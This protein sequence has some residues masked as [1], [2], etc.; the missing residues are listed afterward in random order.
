VR[1]RLLSDVPLGV[2]LSGGLDSSSLVACLREVLGADQEIN[3]FSIGF[4]E[5]S[6]DE[7]DAARLVAR[8]FGTTHHE[9]TFDDGDMLTVLPEVSAYL[10]EPFADPSVLPTYLLCRFA[11]QKVKVALGG[12]GGDELLGGYPTFLATR[13]LRLFQRLPRWS[14]AALGRLVGRLPVSHRNMSVDFLLREYL[15]GAGSEAAMANQIW[16]GAFAPAEQEDLLHADV[17]SELNGFDLAGEMLQR[18]THAAG[19]EPMAR[20]L[21]LYAQTYLQEEILAKVD[22][23][24]MA[25]GLEVRAPFLDPELMTF[26]GRL[27]TSYRLRGTQTKRILKKAA[28]KR[29][30]AAIVHR[31][32][33][34]FGIPA[35]AWLAGSLQEMV[36]DLLSADRVKAQGLFDPA[37]VTRL[38]DE[39]LTHRRNHRKPLWTL[40]MFQLW[41][42]HYGRGPTGAPEAPASHEIN[43]SAP[44]SATQPVDK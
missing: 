35:A 37:F 26:L 42:D 4:R 39:H 30:P 34:G 23:A 6:Y 25:N 16:M 41:Y 18:Y 29:L 32:K 1:R 22:R 7:S 19:A 24:S 36:G 11:R 14:R 13:S 20:L 44:Q 12:D 9:Q 3:T 21:D 8:H 38:V 5:P 31:K 33:Q 27:P 28:L 40:L 10:D 2:F 17:R 43:R 15:R